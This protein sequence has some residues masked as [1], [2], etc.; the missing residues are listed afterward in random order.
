MTYGM[1]LFGMGVGDDSHQR[2]LREAVLMAGGDV[3]VHG[4]GY[5][6]TRGS[7]VVME[8]GSEVVRAVAGVEGVGR[9]LPRVLINGLLSTSAATRPVFLQGVDPGAEDAWRNLSEDVTA[10]TFLRDPP[11]DPLVLGSRLAGRLE[12]ELGGRVVLTASDP[13][14]E[15]TRAL[16]HVT[17]ILETGNREMDELLAFTTV[18]GAQRAVAMEGALT[19]VGVLL[20][21][22]NGPEPVADR[23]RVALG[24]RN[25]DL[26]VLTWREAVPEMVGFVEL[27]D[28]FGYIYIVVIFVVVLFAITNTFLMA[29]MERVRE[30]GLLA[31]LGLRGDRIGGLI[32]RETL[33]LTALAMGAGFV[34]GY[35]CHL[36]ADH[37]GI[38]LA[39]WG[40]DEVEISGVDVADMVI[41]STIN[42]AKWFA[43]SVLVALA[44]LGS[45]LYP[46][47]RA[48]RLAPA[49]AMR[50]F[51]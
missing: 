40:L 31:A 6:A 16:F 43:A 29:V 26:E 18:S 41:R 35:S 37:W 1:T 13:A 42:P 14:G 38:N 44:S 15:V 21:D 3:L 46:A 10:G 34:I 47:W 4:D 45:A 7:D 19:Q 17:G 25:G 28:A 8:S 49:E 20:T 22:G 9:E 48:M 23:I 27:D 2:M 5:W 32:L 51:E 33:L 30:F 11:R 39:M 36:A 24:A 12:V 50:F